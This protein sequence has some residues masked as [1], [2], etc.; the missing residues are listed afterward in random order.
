MS[1]KIWSRDLREALK[2]KKL[3]YVDDKYNIYKD[4]CGNRDPTPG[5]AFRGKYGTKVV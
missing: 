1:K 5:D 2:K 3:A 4:A